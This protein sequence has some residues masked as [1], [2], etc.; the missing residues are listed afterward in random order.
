MDQ[1]SAMR[2]FIRVVE[3]GN[4]TRAADTLAMPKATVTNLIQGLE[5]HLHTKLLNRTTRRVMVTTDGALYY[6]RAAQIV[7][8]LEELDG[9]LSNS[10][11][12][13]TGRLRVEMAGAF[14]DWIV[15]PA[16]C[17]FYQKYPDI[18]VDLGVGDRTVD[19]LAENVDCALRGGTPADQSLIARRVSEV[20][21]LTC[22]AP[23][24][25]EKFGIPT[26]PEELEN[27]HYSVSYFRAQTNRTLPFEF[28][29]DNED[30]EINPRYLLSV[31]DSRTFVNAALNGLGIAQLP[32]FMIRDALAKG[33]LVEILP[34][35]SR[36]PL[37]LYIVYPP[38]RHLSNKVRVFVDW[39][40]KLLSDAKLNDA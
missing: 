2:A 24:Y 37:P 33:D 5:A 3:T 28:R 23:L 38:N 13:P 21:M 9:S 31:N 4:F 26:R 39:L 10:Q 15:V 25:I 14:A 19:Y 27:D 30:L 11:G 6:E 17:D 7:S 8:E 20:E 18:R 16:L 1:L 40:V 22:A 36:E 35:W 29:K 32:R 34:E 12:L